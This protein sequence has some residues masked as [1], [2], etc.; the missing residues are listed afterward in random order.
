M[1]N[2]IETVI[3]YLEIIGKIITYKV[4]LKILIFTTH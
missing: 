4:C 1:N 3:D 2:R